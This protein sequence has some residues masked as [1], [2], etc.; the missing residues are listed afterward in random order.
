M[1]SFLSGAIMMACAAC[2]LFFFKTWKTNG[3]RLFLLFALAFW[4]LSVERWILAA[5]EPANEFR[6]LVYIFRLIAFVL[7]VGAIV[8]KNRSSGR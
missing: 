2:G 5:V 7:I 6:P 8:E 3:D 1:L 4:T